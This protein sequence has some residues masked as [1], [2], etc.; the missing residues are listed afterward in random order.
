VVDPTE[1][2][3]CSLLLYVTGVKQ[4]NQVDVKQIRHQ[5]AASRIWL[6]SSGMT[7]PAV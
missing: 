6:T 5:G 7:V 1:P 2:F 3:V 4:R